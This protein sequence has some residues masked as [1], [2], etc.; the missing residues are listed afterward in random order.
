MRPVAKDLRLI[1]TT[2]AVT[3]HLVRA[4]TLCEHIC[5]GIAQ[6]AEV[7]GNLELEAALLEMARR[8]REIF[9]RGLDAFEDRDVLY[10]RDLKDADDM[11]DLLYSE[12]LG[13]AVNPSKEGAGSPEWRVTAALAAHYLERIA[14]HGVDIGKQTEFLVT[15]QRRHAS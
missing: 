10:A 8:T 2:Q 6:T 3:N 9:G 15:G 7:K 13:L 1:R 4:G 11:V 14:D 12:A 5:H